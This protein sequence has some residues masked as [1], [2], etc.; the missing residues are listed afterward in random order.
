LL[1]ANKHE[2]ILKIETCRWYFNL[3]ESNLSFRSYS[4]NV[5]LLENG[6]ENLLVLYIHQQ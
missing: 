2:N 3:S 4:E 5:G 6:F 1:N